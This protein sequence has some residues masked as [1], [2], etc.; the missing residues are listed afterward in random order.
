VDS[1]F[2]GRSA[3]ARQVWYFSPEERIARVYASPDQFS[4]LTDEDTLD[5]GDLL[6]GFRLSLREVFAPVR[7][8]EEK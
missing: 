6:P 3:G 8:R 5:S 4:T 2:R 1:G 7:P